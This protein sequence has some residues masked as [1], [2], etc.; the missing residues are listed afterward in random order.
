MAKILIV[1]DEEDLAKL[2]SN[3]L[4][5]NGHLCEIVHDGATAAHILKITKYDLVILDL[6]L[7]E[8]SGLDVCRDYRR[9]AG[10]S[11]ILM[12]T[13]RSA[14]SDKI[15]GFEAGADD[16]LTKPFHLDELVVR[17]RALLRRG[18]VQN[19]NVIRVGDLE[20]DTERHLVT[21]GHKSIELLPKEFRLLEF[22]AR[23]PSRVFSTKELLE[24]VWETDS[25]A[26]NDTVRGHITRIRKKVDAPNKQSIIVTVYGVGYKLEPIP[27]LSKA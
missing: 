13:A 21:K 1:E 6:M 8:I 18:E 5:S 4:K 11:P 16:F 17:V 14:L 27:Q 15:V 20:I 24:H 2:V 9:H 25:Q 12:L 19:S 7:P 22:L 26:M 23:H 3:C 10:A